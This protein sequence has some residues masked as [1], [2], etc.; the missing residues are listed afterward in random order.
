[1]PTKP[2]RQETIT[3]AIDRL[4][5]GAARIPDGVTA[6]DPLA[7]AEHL[8]EASQAGGSRAFAAYKTAQRINEEG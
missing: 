8:Q 4:A 1:M 6:K 5:A 3:Q 7:L 2:S